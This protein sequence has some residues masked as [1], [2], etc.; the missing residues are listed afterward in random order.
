MKAGLSL[1]ELAQKIESQQATKRDY[2]TSTEHMSCDIAEDGDLR[3]NIGDE[4]HFKL[5]EV[6]HRQVASDLDIPQ[7]FYDKLRANMP[8]LLATNV[9]RFLHHT[10]K[11]RMLRTIGET[12]RAFLS[13]SYRPLENFDLAEAALPVLIDLDVEVVSSQITDTR[14]YIK[15]VD[16]RVMTEL[17][18]GAKFGDGKHTIV[19]T[20]Q[21]YP[22]ITISNSEVG[23]G[24]LSI[25][26]GLYDGFCT[27]LSFFGERSLRKYHVGGKHEVGGEEL[28]AV[29]S[30]QTRKITDAAVWAQVRDVV[31]AAFDKAKFDALVEKVKGATQDVIDGDPIKV[32]DFAAK[33]LNFNEGEKSSIL[34]HLIQGGELSRFGLYNAVTRTAEDLPDYDRASEFERIGGKIIE[35]PAN[36]W[37]EIARAA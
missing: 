27:N 9:N 22:A 35:L 11:D 25:Q 24:A 26:G 37:R 14:L 10:L 31:K 32:I 3:L 4:H 17:P 19:K 21:L 12:G 18:A 6:A 2:V 30:D 1:V 16:K 33:K 20:R 36:D 15:A 34:K 13:N 8:D 29:L 5:N 23:M 28:Y 7:K